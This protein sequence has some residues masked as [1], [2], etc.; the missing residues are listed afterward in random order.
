[1]ISSVV[2]VIGAIVVFIAASAFF[3]RLTRFVVSAYFG[4]YINFRY[5]DANGAI[6][7]R[8]VRCNNDDELIRILDELKENRKNEK[9][10]V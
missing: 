4:Q 2:L 3:Y 9:A 8:R 5:I 6:H 10:G 1:M 7:Q